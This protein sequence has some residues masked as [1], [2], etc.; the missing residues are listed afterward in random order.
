[1][2]EDLITITNCGC[3]CE[4][5]IVPKNHHK[6]YGIP[7]Y[8]R[9]HNPV[10]NKGLTKETN[11]VI[12]LAAEKSK[13]E[14]NSRLKVDRRFY[15]D[16]KK[17]RC[18]CGCTKEIEIIN[19]HKYSGVPAH[20]HGHNPALDYGWSKDLT[21]ETDV[22][23]KRA[24]E[25]R[26]KKERKSKYTIINLDSEITLYC[27]CGCGEKLSGIYRSNKLPK[28]LN[29]HN[30]ARWSKGL[31]AE[32]DS[33]IKK[34]AESKKL[35]DNAKLKPKLRSYENDKVSFC[36]CGCNQQIEFKKYHRIYGV[37]N[38]IVGH[39]GR[40]L[41]NKNRLRELIRQQQFSG[42][43]IEL[44]L[45]EALTKENIK[46]EIQKSLFGIPD[47]FIEPNICI[48]ADGDYWHANP[49]KYSKDTIFRNKTAIEIWNKD[50]KVTNTLIEK[51]YIVL[52]FWECEINNS[53]TLCIN[54][55]KKAI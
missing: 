16:N 38:Y 17:Y 14:Y 24:A 36:I 23:V 46:F 18:I 54:S 15:E 20:K 55:I 35:A 25:S 10:W 49:T 50:K 53:I 5:I 32:T 2:N 8:L 40:T 39:N 28:F 33:R 48:F 44:L 12:K 3:G 41:E 30:T 4:G 42:T 7:K 29:G 27:T 6:Y 43:S 34:L 31:T 11:E 13:V 1:M 47:I 9:G 51:G 19:E 37:P 45:Q 21:K 52:R 26:N 22:R